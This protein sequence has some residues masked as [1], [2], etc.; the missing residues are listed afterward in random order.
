LGRTDSLRDLLLTT[1]NDGTNE[2]IEVAFDF[3]CCQWLLLH[4]FSSPA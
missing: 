1:E 3:S 2:A 4:G